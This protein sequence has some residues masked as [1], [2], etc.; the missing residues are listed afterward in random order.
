MS[1]SGST[2]ESMVS[3][4]PFDTDRLVSEGINYFI[5]NQDPEKVELVAYDNGYAIK[6][7]TDED[8][9][10]SAKSFWENNVHPKLKGEV[11]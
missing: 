3:K 8:N 10:E 2:F 5:S 4:L 1:P 9:V 7:Y 11:D 6:V